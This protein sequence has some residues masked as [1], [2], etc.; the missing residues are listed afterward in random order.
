MRGHQ[1]QNLLDLRFLEVLAQQFGQVL[2][3]LDIHVRDK[4]I[5]PGVEETFLKRLTRVPVFDNKHGA[6]GHDT[7]DREKGRCGQGRGREVSDRAFEVVRPVVSFRRQRPGR[8][9]AGADVDA[10]QEDRMESSARL[11]SGVSGYQRR[12]QGHRIGDEAGE[13]MS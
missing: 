4:A 10:A 3:L 2:G 1:S 9:V 13:V 5:N 12:R 11:V 7:E 6:L 8:F